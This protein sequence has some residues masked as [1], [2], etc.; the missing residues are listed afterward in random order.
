M[1]AV[2]V[3]SFCFYIIMKINLMYLVQFDS[4]LISSQS[5][6]SSYSI[7]YHCIISMYVWAYMNIHVHALALL[8]TCIHSTRHI[9]K[10]KHINRHAYTHISM[11]TPTCVHNRYTGIMCSHRTFILLFIVH[12][13]SNYRQK[14]TAVSPLLLQSLPPTSPLPLCVC[15]HGLHFP[16]S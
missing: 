5:C 13:I 7:I 4:I 8:H 16:V 1:P 11:T 14:R 9:Q 15:H 6:I 3:V 2:A 10:Y 12:I